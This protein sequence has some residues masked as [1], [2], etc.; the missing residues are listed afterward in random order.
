[1]D[2]QNLESIPIA[3]GNIDFER[4]FQFLDKIQYNGDY[5]VEATAF[6][7]EGNV[8]FEMLNQCF[9]FIKNKVKR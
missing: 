1:M 5:T 4:F 7:D 8:D 6:S 2:W 3:K 9:K